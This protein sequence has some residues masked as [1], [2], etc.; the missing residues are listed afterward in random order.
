MVFFNFVLTLFAVRALEKAKTT[1]TYA[2]IHTVR[3][4]TQVSAYTNDSG[5]ESDGMDAPSTH[6]RRKRLKTANCNM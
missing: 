3:S 4:S 1:G 6:G 2:A 5:S